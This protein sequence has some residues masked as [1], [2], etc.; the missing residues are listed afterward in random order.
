M[1]KEAILYK[2]YENYVECLACARK[3]K[4]P[5]NLYGFCGVRYNLDNKLYLVNYGIFIS[6]ALD[7]IEKKPLYHFYPGHTALSFGT[8]GCSFACSYCQNWEI[9][10]RR[11]V[12]GIKLEPEEIV[13]LAKKYNTNI[14]TF[15]YNEPSIYSEYAYDVAK[16]AKKEGIKITWVSNGYLTDEAIDFASKFLDAIDIDIKGNANKEFARKNILIPDYEA[17][18]NAIEEFYKKGIHVEI[19]D[20]IVPEIGDNLEDARKLAKYIYDIM[21]ENANI[22]FLRFYPEYKLSNLYP[23]PI[24][25]LE[26]HVE[27]ARE[28]GIKYTY[29]GNVPG[30]KYEN[31]YC[32]NC[33][34]PVIKRYGFYVYEVNLDGD[35]CKFC[36][37]KIFLD[38]NAKISEISYPEPVLLNKKLIKVELK[39]KNFVEE[40]INNL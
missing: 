5:K 12:I 17:T 9:S 3:C 10:Q 1:V 28:E 2:S 24:E 20:L 26:K 16:I 13:E 35:R 27:I 33:G 29:I 30:H 7:P 19:T 32:P 31:T 15:T 22:H 14:I 39:D 34:R 6:V 8:T 38:G 21:G 18:L 40:E 36:G 37:A 25:T 23:T 11:R 4:I